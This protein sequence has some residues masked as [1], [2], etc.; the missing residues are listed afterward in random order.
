M[1]L[2]EIFTQMLRVTVSIATAAENILKY[3]L[4]IYFSEKTRLDISCD[5][6][7]C[8]KWQALFS[9]KNNNKRNL[10]LAATILLGTF[11]VK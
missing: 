11:K 10:L 1:L 5:C 2:A 7:L 8:M 6:L 4:F 3:F 9:L